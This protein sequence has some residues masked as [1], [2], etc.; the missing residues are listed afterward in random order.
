[1]GQKLNQKKTSFIIQREYREKKMTEMKISMKKC[2][3]TAEQRRRLRLA[4][5]RIIKSTRPL[6]QYNSCSDSS[7]SDEEPIKI[8][9]SCQNSSKFSKRRNV[10]RL[11]IKCWW[12]FRNKKLPFFNTQNCREKILDY[13]L[14]WLPNY[15]FYW[16]SAVLS[17][18]LLFF[19][20]CTSEK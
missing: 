4:I 6:K 13:L 19:V 17:L 10:K 16:Y 11:S 3:M 5:K 2:E 7:S 9:I 12:I 20:I 14:V 1:M 15:N 18:L 8:S